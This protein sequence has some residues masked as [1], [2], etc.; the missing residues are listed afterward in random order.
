[1]RLNTMRPALAFLIASLAAALPAGTPVAYY[2][3]AN[4]AT[5]ATLKATLNDI[6]TAGS[7][8][9][10]YSN[11]NAALYVTDED[12]AN[13]NN[14]YMVYGRDSRPK[15]L[16]SGAADGNPAT[17]GWNREH[18][19]PQS[20]L[21]PSSVS[22]E[23][24]V[25][26]LHSLMPADTD[27][28]TQR[29]NEGYDNVTSPVYTDVF[30]NRDDNTRWEPASV[31]KGRVARAILYMDT[32][33]EGEGSNPDLAVS[34]AAPGLYNMAYKTTLLNWHRLYP[35]TAW[36]RLRNYKVYNRQGNANP[37][38]DR[39]EW[40]AVVF[41]GTAWSMTDNDTLTLGA[42]NRA[43]VATQSASAQNVPLLSLNATLAANQFHIATVAIS[44]LGTILDSEVA[45]VKLWLDVDNNGSASAAD[46]LLDTRTFSGGAATFNLGAHPFYVAPGTMNF[47][48]TA[49][50]GS[51]VAGTR[52]LGV[53]VNANGITRDLSGGNDINPTFS[54]LD[55]GL[56]NV[57]GSVANGDSITVGSTNRAGVSVPAGSV[58]AA[59]LSLNLTLAANEW[60]LAQVNIS[61]LGTSAD[62]DVLDVTL[63][64]DANN[65]GA[66]D[67]S[68]SLLGTAVLSGGA[69]SLVLD[70]P[71]RILPGTK[72]FLL[73][74]TMSP[75]ATVGNTVQLRVNASGI[76]SGPT[77]GTDNNPANAALDST[78]STIIA[79]PAGTTDN[80]VISEVF[81]GT[82]GSLKYVEIHNPTTATI[83]LDT[84]RNYVLRRY[85][86]GNLTPG[87]VD[88]TG[89]V[90][91]GGYWFIVN[92][93]T[94]YNTYFPSGTVPNQ[95]NSTI[96]SH[97]GNDCYELYNATDGVVDTFAGDNLGNNP[98]FA[99]DIVAM[100]K[101]DELP[102]NGAWGGSV[103]PAANAD[104]PSG[105]WSTRVITAGNGNAATVG[106]PGGFNLPVRLSGFAVE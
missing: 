9:V 19:F 21:N 78:A 56:A 103:Q 57:S 4:P 70:T 5:S 67:A 55:S 65:N 84:P 34:D 17:G 25:S 96:I 33:Y 51:S 50:I 91:A 54:N 73:A 80:L 23:P 86:N 105:F 28:N 77:G 2:D 16:S 44:K 32:R 97:N 48:V 45:S 6:V 14:V 88:I 13:A 24:M 61:E 69:A 29:S 7:I 12:P 106:N 90:A 83:N 72:N 85:A 82:A 100:R 30:G 15:S 75:A 8:Q 58:D 89:T 74:A 79:A 104:S 93:L 62:S 27:I 42:T 53:R 1:M 52:T 3:S 46:V 71:Y 49:T 81:E 60:D 37:F 47:L 41:G 22:R 63:Y 87:T 66:V 76:L 98:N 94:D 59:F 36:E 11:T 101:M 68:D 26:D 38:V 102:N 95:A 64:L 99:I 92:N 43:P 40:A 10:G 20:F 39:P 35:P 18:C 31:D